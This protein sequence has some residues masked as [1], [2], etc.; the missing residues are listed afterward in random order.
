MQYR[1]SSNIINVTNQLFFAYQKLA[2]KLRIFI[3]P[4]T[5]LTKAV[6]FIYA[7]KEKQKV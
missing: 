2:S 6:D 4:P 1:I 3:S 7:L 5:K